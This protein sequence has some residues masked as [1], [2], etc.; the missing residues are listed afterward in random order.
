MRLSGGIRTIDDDLRAVQP[1]AAAWL[2]AV[3]ESRPWNK[4]VCCLRQ[5]YETLF[6]KFKDRHRNHTHLAQ[7]VI[8]RP[9]A[10]SSKPHKHF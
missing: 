9:I 1:L 8:S 3:N 4:Q 5:R 2:L 10:Y 7:S 6:G